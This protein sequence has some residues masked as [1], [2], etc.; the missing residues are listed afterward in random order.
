[1]KKPDLDDPNYHPIN[2]LGFETESDFLFGHAM[3]SFSAVELN[4]E[5]WSP[6]ASKEKK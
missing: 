6:R 4:G 1:M 2:E 3:K 5:I